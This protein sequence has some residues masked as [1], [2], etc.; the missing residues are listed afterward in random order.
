MPSLLILE[1]RPA[2]WHPRATA[3]SGAIGRRRSPP[4]VHHRHH[5]RRRRCG[6]RHQRALPSTA[7]LQEE[8]GV[9]PAARCFIRASLKAGGVYPPSIKEVIQVSGPIPLEASTYDDARRDVVTIPHALGVCRHFLAPVAARLRPRDRLRRPRPQ[10]LLAD[11]GRRSDDRTHRQP[12][13]QLRLPQL[14]GGGCGASSPYT[15][16]M[17]ADKSVGTCRRNRKVPHFQE[18]KS[19]RGRPG[20]LNGF[21]PTGI[22]FA[23]GGTAPVQ[24]EPAVPARGKRHPAPPFRRR[25]RYGGVYRGADSRRSRFLRLAMRLSLWLWD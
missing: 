5:R 7:R 1:A 21:G 16:T 6:P 18:P 12:G 19:A 22:G 9:I 13:F 8:L 2:P 14:T 24:P 4:L 23:R 11:G 25:W 3:R 20:G 15:V 10:R 17:D